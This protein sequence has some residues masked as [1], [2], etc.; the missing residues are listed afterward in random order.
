M[1]T[2]QSICPHFLACDLM[3]ELNIASS[4]PMSVVTIDFAMLTFFTPIV[5]QLHLVLLVNLNQ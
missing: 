5:N 3:I 2:L 4:Y 1:L